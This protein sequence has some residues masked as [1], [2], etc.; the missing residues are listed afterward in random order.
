MLPKKLHFITKYYQERKRV[1]NI[2]IF[3]KY[4]MEGAD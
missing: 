3:N 4:Y 2:D 1:T